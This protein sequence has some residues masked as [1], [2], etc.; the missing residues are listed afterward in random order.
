M[1]MAPLPLETGLPCAM[2]SLRV[3]AENPTGAWP[4]S[5]KGTDYD[6]A[7]GLDT[8]AHMCPSTA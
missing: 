7:L 6:A 3:S 8:K 5:T 4:E 2:W 1:K